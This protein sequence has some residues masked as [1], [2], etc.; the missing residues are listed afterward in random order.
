MKPSQ[1]KEAIA[2]VVDAK[3][4]SFIWGDSGIGK[5]EVVEQVAVA[6][7]LEFRDVRLNLMDPTDLKGFPVPDLKKG[8]MRWLVADFL[9]QD[10]KSEGILFLDEMNLASPAVMAAAYQLVLNRAIGEYKMPDGWAV[11]AA[12]NGDKV[13]ANISRM[14][15]PLSN[16][17]L[18]IDFELDVED[19]INYQMDQGMLS[20]QVA[21]HRFRTNLLHVFKPEE[22]P[23]AFPTPRSWSTV[24]KLRNTK[25][26]RGLEYELI[27]GTVGEAAAAEFMAYIKHIKD[28]P[29]VDEITLDPDGTKVPSAPNQLY[30]LTTALSMATKDTGF[31]RFMMYVT[32]MPLEFQV[33]YVRDALRR[34]NNLKHDPVFAKWS[35]ANKAVVL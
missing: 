5:S 16:R 22:N 27:K 34:N 15:A 2:A 31:Q 21:F 26:S 18:H 10:P 29:T 30:A 11:L 9:P 3:I 23:R 7:G 12:G 8:L 20:D 33:V 13:R 25:M 24:N 4:S 28:L 1:A 14:P 19:Y 32:R 35:I 17:F 6:S